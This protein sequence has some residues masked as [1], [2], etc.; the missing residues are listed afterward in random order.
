MNIR[1]WSLFVLV[2]GVLRHVQAFD[3]EGEAQIFRNRALDEGFT[4]KDTFNL[5]YAK[6][7]SH[8]PFAI[9]ETIQR[10]H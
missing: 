5:H 4:D 2:D 9:I 1:R 6:M 8:L 10:E 7:H 3:K